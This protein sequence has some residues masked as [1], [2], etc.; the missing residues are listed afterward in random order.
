M[1]EDFSIHGYAHAGGGSIGTKKPKRQ[2]M[3]HVLAHE[4]FGDVTSLSF[5]PN[6]AE[7]FCAAIMKAARAARRNKN[8]AIKL[9]HIQDHE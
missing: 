2:P 4:P 1:S 5:H 7:E 3:V 9:E 8:F 6:Y